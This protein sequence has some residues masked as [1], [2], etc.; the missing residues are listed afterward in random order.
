MY[1][2]TFVRY[3]RVGDKVTP[4][5]VTKQWVNRETRKGASGNDSRLDSAFRVVRVTELRR[6][7]VNEPEP[8]DPKV[9]AWTSSDRQETRERVMNLLERGQPEGECLVRE[10]GYTERWLP[11]AMPSPLPAYVAGWTLDN[12]NGW[13]TP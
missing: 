4:V 3:E 5:R 11:F 13:V 2:S 1:Q 12:G 6:F 10:A 9:P 8:G 7:P